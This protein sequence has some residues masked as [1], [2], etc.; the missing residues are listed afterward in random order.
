MRHLEGGQP[1]STLDAGPMICTMN[2]APTPPPSPFKKIFGHHMK[3]SKTGEVWDAGRNLQ[4]FFR[5]YFLYHL[6]DKL[7]I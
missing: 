3:I 7:W 5:C 4:F 6:L 2:D 1:R